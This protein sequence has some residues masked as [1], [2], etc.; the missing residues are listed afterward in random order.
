[1]KTTWGNNVT[2]TYQVLFKL[3]TK[4]RKIINKTRTFSSN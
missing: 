1:M 2:L 3:H 4:L